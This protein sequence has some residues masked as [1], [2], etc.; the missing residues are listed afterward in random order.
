VIARRRAVAQANL[1]AWADHAGSVKRERDQVVRAAI[2]AGVPRSV[3]HR[4]TGLAR[5]TIDRISPPPQ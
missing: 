1:A 5:T 2:R 4:I 3:I